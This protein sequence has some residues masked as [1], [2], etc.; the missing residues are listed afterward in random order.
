MRPRSEGS[1]PAHSA[2]QHTQLPLC[3]HADHNGTTA[4]S[5]TLLADSRSRPNRTADHRAQQALVDVEAT[6]SGRECV[7]WQ[8]WLAAMAQIGDRIRR[9]ILPPSRRTAFAAPC[10][11]AMPLVTSVAASS[12]PSSLPSIRGVLGLQLAAL[13]TDGPAEP[14]GSADDL[15]PGTLL[16]V[17]RG[18]C[19][20]RQ[21]AAPGAAKLRQRRVVGVAAH[22]RPAATRQ[23]SASASVIGSDTTA[24]RLPI[25]TIDATLSGS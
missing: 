22:R 7:K 13:E 11:S 15:L 20:A 10:P 14:L 17:A 19:A 21:N 1:N 16:R 6:S 9:P 2:S 8:P 23:G 18:L 24:A 25:S 3:R 4:S 12:P 5:T